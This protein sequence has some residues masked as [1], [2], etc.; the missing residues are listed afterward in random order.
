M[1]NFAINN[2]A[3]Q[4]GIPI[5][6]LT[7][8]PYLGDMS[9]MAQISISLNEQK[10]QNLKKRSW[11]KD[12]SGM[13]FGNLVVIRKAQ[14]DNYSRPRWVC[15]CIC[16]TETIVRGESLR[17]GNTK[18]CGCMQHPILDLVG[19][20]FGLLTALKRVGNSKYHGV[21]WFCKCDCGDT[22]IVPSSLLRNGST[23][24]CGCLNRRKGVESPNYKGGYKA[25]NGYLCTSVN[26]KSVLLHRIA[27]EKHLGRKLT[28]DE[29]VH[30]INGNRIDNRIENLEIW[31][32]K[33]PSGQRIEDITKFCL[34][35]LEL[36][37]PEYLAKGKKCK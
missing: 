14:S 9:I 27:M 36:Y 23:K 13:K 5:P 37:A 32:G 4:G 18:S 3:I 6:L 21:T 20:K 16:G 30:H 17:S 34:K 11:C 8:N 2:E 7:N 29:S 10:S 15:R 28:R 12:L 31:T 25:K 24:S 33:H 19:K 22:K 1:L 26:G 35:H